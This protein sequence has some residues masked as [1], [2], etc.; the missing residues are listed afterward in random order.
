MG[1]DLS[2]MGLKAVGGLV[3]E[4][5]GRKVLVTVYKGRGSA[6]LCFTFLG[7]EKDAP[8]NARLFFDPEKRM[9]FYTFSKGRVNGV[10]QAVGD[11]ICTF[12]SKMP[13]SELLALARSKAQ[14]S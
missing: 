5:G 4:I 11:R 13:M 14:A 12:V 7:T 6:V 2:A 1:Y 3:Q 9:N 10:M 8:P